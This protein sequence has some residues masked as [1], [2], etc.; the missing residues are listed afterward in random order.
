MAVPL[1]CSSHAS[2]QPK[3]EVRVGT[4]GVGC[5][6]FQDGTHVSNVS[7]NV[8]DIGKP[9][10]PALTRGETSVVERIQRYVHS[11]TLRFAFLETEEPFVVF[12]ATNGPCDD[13]APGYW[14]MNDSSSGTFFEP[15]EAP[16]FV[17]PIPGEVAPTAGPWMRPR[18]STR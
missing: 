12:D 18:S 15:G 6:T 5:L 3:A 14:I 7:Y 9:G 10:T 13:S 4:Y 1:A 2:S 17:H 11:K 8:D 16:S